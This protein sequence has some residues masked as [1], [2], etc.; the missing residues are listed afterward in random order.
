MRALD[1]FLKC[2]LINLWICM[3]MFTWLG[4]CSCWRRLAIRRLWTSTG[5]NF[6]R[7]EI[8]LIIGLTV[9]KL[10]NLKNM[11]PLLLLKLLMCVEM[12]VGRQA[13]VN[14]HNNLSDMKNI[15]VLK[16]LH[17]DRTLISFISLNSF[18]VPQIYLLEYVYIQH[19][20]LQTTGIY[21]FFLAVFC[22]NRKYQWLWGPW[23]QDTKAREGHD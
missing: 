13:S 16:K 2:A 8:V 12:H 3:E 20:Y 17:I 6:A 9:S 5:N 4:K 18:I 22:H 10:I 15:S 11:H 21:I 23:S 7:K 1:C 14:P 19:E